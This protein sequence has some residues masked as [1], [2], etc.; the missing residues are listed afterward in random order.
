[1]FDFLE[2]TVVGREGLY[3]PTKLSI[4][5]TFETISLW[6][7]PQMIPPASNFIKNRLRRKCFPASFVKF[8]RT[9]FSLEIPRWLFLYYTELELTNYIEVLFLDLL[10][11][12]LINCLQ[13]ASYNLDVGMS[14]F[15]FFFKTLSHFLKWYLPSP[16]VWEQWPR[17]WGAMGS[18]F[19]YSMFK[20]KPLVNSMID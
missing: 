5:N 14:F 17:D 16:W 15:F 3:V 20:T 10:Q 6:L 2:L 12:F 8:L 19:G 1:M 18:Q 13:I 7:N 4:F 9:A 11:P